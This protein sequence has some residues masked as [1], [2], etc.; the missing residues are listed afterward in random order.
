MEVEIHANDKESL[1]MVFF[2]HNKKGN[3]CIRE[4]SGE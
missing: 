3:L 1:F 4:D 2:P